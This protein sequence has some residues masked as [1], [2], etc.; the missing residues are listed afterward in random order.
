ME[1]VESFRGIPELWYQEEEFRYIQDKCRFVVDK[2]RKGVETQ[3]KICIRGLESS[4]NPGERAKNQLR[5]WK[6]VLE[7]RYYQA[8][9]GV[10]DDG[11]LQR[12]CSRFSEENIITAAY[13][14][15][16]DAEVVIRMNTRRMS[17]RSLCGY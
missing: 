5:L 8:K 16:K 1:I 15:V 13:R 3:R 11:L 12:V 14:G 17:R 2:F 9:L 10:K 7:L 6:L 4:L